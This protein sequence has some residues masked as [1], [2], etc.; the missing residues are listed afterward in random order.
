MKSFIGA[1]EAAA[2]DWLDRRDVPSE[3]L[4]ALLSKMLVHALTAAAALD[5]TST[6]PS[7]KTA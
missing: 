6:A 4:V 2:L 1:V 5:S 7:T 3:V